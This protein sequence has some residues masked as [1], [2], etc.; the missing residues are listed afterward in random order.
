MGQSIRLGAFVIV[1]LGIFGV[2]VFMLG[3]VESKFQANYR[4][5]AQFQNVSGLDEG[6]SVRVG[7]LH[8]GTVRK[9][10]LPA[11]PDG[12]L[13]VVMDLSRNTRNLVK[14]DSLA[15]IQSEGLVGDKYVE[16]SFGSK[17]SPA[18]RSGDTI[19]S[20]PPIDISDLIGK[21]NQILDSTKGA[22]DNLQSASENVSSI[23]ARINGGRGTVGALI[24]N[25]SMYQEANA[26]VKA[27]RED[28]D[29]L[30]HN[31]LLRGYFNQ[32]GF[33]D[34]AEI[35]KQSIAQLPSE[36]P[37]KVF[38]FDTRRLFDKPDSAKLKDEKA[39]NEAGAYLQR[40]IPG[41][42]VIEASVGPK[43]DADKDRE[44]SQARAYAVRS[45]LVDHFKLDDRRLK[46]IGIGKTDG[47]ASLR[48]LLYS[49]VR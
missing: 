27:L 46:I 45:Y 37:Q 49:E 20:Q 28:A 7:G 1:T 30:K 10:E 9:I 17:D 12:K 33:A 35:Q 38:T 47:E 15:S 2:F 36:P 4:L 11:S 40:G 43:G 22:L 48:I 8:E 34:P 39:L 23:T 25:Q 16:I 3:N 21:T 5:N 6:A 31:F 42:A 18:V 29:A 13:T 24:N 32:H 26:S 14:Q 19:R 41:H 44:L